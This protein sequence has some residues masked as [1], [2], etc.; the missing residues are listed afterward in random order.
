MEDAIM[1]DLEELRSISMGKV[2]EAF[3]AMNVWR[4]KMLKKGVSD[5]ILAMKD[6]STEALANEIRNLNGEMEHQRTKR[7]VE[8]SDVRRSLS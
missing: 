8:L 4:T 2:L 1:R 5:A 3:L 7:M 6:L